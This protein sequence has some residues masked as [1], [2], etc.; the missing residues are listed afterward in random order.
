ML[1]PDA[2]H[3]R[4]GD[5]TSR[6]PADR[7]RRGSG[8]Q[9]VDR[10]SS[11]R[12]GGDVASPLTADLASAQHDILRTQAVL[13]GLQRLRSAIAAPDRSGSDNTAILAQAMEGSIYG[14]SKTLEP[15]AG[16]LGRILRQ[17]DGGALERLLADQ[18]LR[19][20]TLTSRLQNVQSL[21]TPDDAEGLLRSV[22]G[23]LENAGD[24]PVNIRRRNAADL[25]L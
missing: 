7:L 25:L 14:G 4:K 5:L 24:A 8:S 1:I 15:L 10:S 18:D 6:S 22:L 19:L 9:R 21:M 16:E 20:R 17:T 3:V 23:D 13:A 2:N 11:T 12:N